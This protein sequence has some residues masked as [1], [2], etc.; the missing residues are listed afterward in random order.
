MSTDRD[1]RAARERQGRL[2]AIVIAVSALVSIG[3]NYAGEAI[4]L[5]NRQIGLVFLAAMGGFG[6]GLILAIRMWIA[7][8]N[9][10]G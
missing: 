7:D 4:G 10:R 2:A 9:S 5:S 3:A 8:R 6:F 1:A